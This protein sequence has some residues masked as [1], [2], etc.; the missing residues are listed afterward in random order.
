MPVS[1]SARRPAARPVLGDPAAPSTVTVL[2]SPGRNVVR[3]PTVASGPHVAA[4]RDRQYRTE[5]LS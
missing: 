5:H 3:M 4:A 1:S 2:R